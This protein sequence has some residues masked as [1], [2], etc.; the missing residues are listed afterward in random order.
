MT[1]FLAARQLL[2]PTIE[3]RRPRRVLMLTASLLLLLALAP[4]PA[5]LTATQTG[6]GSSVRTV[7]W[8][9]AE[10]MCEMDVQDGAHG[11]PWACVRSSDRWG[12]ELQVLR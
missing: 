12:W 4:P 1:P 11:L 7:G 6:V 8:Y 3:G 10:R 2:S 9:P 5:G